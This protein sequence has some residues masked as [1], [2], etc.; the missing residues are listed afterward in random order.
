MSNAAISSPQAWE[1]CKCGEPGIG[2]K[3]HS[4]EFAIENAM[5]PSVV[6]ASA[7]KQSRSGGRRDCF[8]V[9]LLAM[10]GEIY[11]TKIIANRYQAMYRQ[12]SG[13]KARP[14]S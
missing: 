1:D 3:N 6:I 8:V 14:R 12:S 11:F 5:L 2:R 10:T 4:Y 9:S 13:K 7:A